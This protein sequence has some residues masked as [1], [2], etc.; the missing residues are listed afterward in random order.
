VSQDYLDLQG[1]PLDGQTSILLQAYWWNSTPTLVTFAQ[2]SL[3]QAIL[4]CALERYRLAHGD[5][6]ASLPQLVPRFLNQVLPDVPHGRPMYYQREGS[7]RFTLR[8]LGANG[9]SDQDNPRSDDWLWAFPVIPS[10]APSDPSPRL[11]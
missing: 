11:R 2:C 1:L 5:Y 10:N 7:D 8:G 4:A 9:I 6:P 3:N